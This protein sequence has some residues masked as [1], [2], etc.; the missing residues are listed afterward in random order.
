MKNAFTI[1]VED[2]FQVQA[3]AGVIN[4]EDWDQYRLRVE[5]NTYRILDMLSKKN[6][7]G[8]FFVLGW[9]AKKCPQ[10]VKRIA[11]EGHEIASH[12]MSH[13]LIYN[14]S[15]AVFKKE[16]IDS[17]SLLE[18][19]CQKEVIGYRAATYSITEASKWALDIIYDAGFKYD[20]SIFPITHDNYGMQLKDIDPHILTT[21]TG[22]KLIEF[23][24]SVYR[25]FG[26]NIPVAGGGYFRLFPY[27]LTKTLLNRVNKSNRHFL[28]YLH[29]WEID[30][31]QP[32]IDNAGWKSKFRHY[33]NLQKT[34]G[35]LNCLLSDFNFDTM[36]NVLEDGGFL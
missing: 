12:G 11:D 6:I 19:L 22:N 25:F 34:E 14:Q 4:P 10:I 18:D 1:D 30:P 13:Q 20:S 32:V 27:A 33:N 36:A 35:R 21:D 8:T 5:D 26:K 28:F 2:F 23:P 3:F 24:I 17:K 16:T 15:K 7:K 29:P 31:G 9:V